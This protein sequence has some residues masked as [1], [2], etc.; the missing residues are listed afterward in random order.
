MLKDNE[1]FAGWILAELSVSIAIIIVLLGSLALA[2]NSFGRMNEYQLNRQRCAAAAQAQLDSIAATGQQIEQTEV[3]RLW[4]GIATALEQK[5]G[6]GDWEGMIMVVVTA[7]T[8]N[9]QKPV[10]IT[11]ARYVLAKQEP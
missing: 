4:P 2:L 11:L 5:P 7:R 1:R 10:S 3:T 8:V 9:T 6:S